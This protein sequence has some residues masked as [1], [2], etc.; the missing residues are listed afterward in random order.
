[1][2]QKRIKCRESAGSIPASSLFC[3]ICPFLSA[4][5]TCGPVLFEPKKPSSYTSCNWSH[6]LLSKV[7]LR[8]ASV[9]LKSQWQ[10]AQ[11]PDLGS[12]KLTLTQILQELWQNKE[13][14][15]YSNYSIVQKAGYSTKFPF[16]NPNH[17]A[18]LKVPQLH[19]HPTDPNDLILTADP[20]AVWLSGPVVTSRPGKASCS[21]MQRLKPQH[22]KVLFS[23]KVKDC[24]NNM[25]K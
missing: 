5:V 10:P 6:Y 20:P 11:V 18:E 16:S 13:P 25:Q 12:S 21:E 9:L 7:I 24:K 23:H 17:L 2:S 3:L 4:T 15:L 22:Q 8:R 14:I 19:G 1:M